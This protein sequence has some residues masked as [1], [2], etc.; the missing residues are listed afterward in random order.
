MPLL[1]W[2]VTG[3][4][5]RGLGLC[6]AQSMWYL[7]WTEWHWDRFCSEFFG[8]TLSVSFHCGSLLIYHVGGWTVGPFVATVQRDCLTPSAWTTITTVLLTQ[9]ISQL[10]LSMWVNLLKVDHFLSLWNSCRRT[11]I[12]RKKFGVNRIFIIQI[13]GIFNTWFLLS[14]PLLPSIH[15]I[16]L[17]QCQCTSHQWFSCRL[18]VPWKVRNNN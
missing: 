11:K 12:V 2:L 17:E 8:F 10:L 4:H 5:H 3:F 18:C 14:C 16:F 7:W 15:H 13:I 1:R 6:P 9:D